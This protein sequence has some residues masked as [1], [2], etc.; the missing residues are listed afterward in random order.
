MLKQPAF[1]DALQGT[2]FPKTYPQPKAAVLS[3]IDFCDVLEFWGSRFA[4][5][6]VQG[7]AQNGFE[8]VLYERNESLGSDQGHSIEV[9]VHEDMEYCE[10]A[11]FSEP[12]PHDGP[13]VWAFTTKVIDP[14]VPSAIP[15]VICSKCT[16]MPNPYAGPIKGVYSIGCT[17]KNDQLD[18]LVQL[19]H[20]R[21]SPSTILE[22][23]DI[24]P[25]HV[26][27]KD[28]DLTNPG[29]IPLDAA[30]DQIRTELDAK[31]T[32]D[33]MGG[34]F[35]RPSGPITREV[36][37]ALHKGFEEAFSELAD[38]P[39]KACKLE[40]FKLDGSV[41]RDK[42][43]PVNYQQIELRTVAATSC[44]EKLID[45]MLTP[46]VKARKPHGDTRCFCDSCMVWA[47][48]AGQS[49][50]LLLVKA[51]YCVSI[52]NAEGY[53]QDPKPPTLMGGYDVEERASELMLMPYGELRAL[54]KALNV[55]DTWE[56]DQL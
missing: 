44:G 51:N 14:L 9:W 11:L 38:S 16:P 15:D 41:R 12:F 26:A 49:H 35:K 30:L 2:L 5:F 17:D 4:A 50:A 56:P 19:Q 52:A 33:G 20:S 40:G 27:A 10:V 53:G 46:P 48:G 25:D 3:D 31:V 1:L 32:F 8:G 43:L 24:D 55:K 18:A 22:M 34:P 13:P 29:Q 23:F 36:I 37:E 42:P 47:D 39:F 21:I 54:G 45:E 7:E 6:D 28:F